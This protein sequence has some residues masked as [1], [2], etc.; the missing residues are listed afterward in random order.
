MAF[1]YVHGALLRA[2]AAQSPEKAQA[3]VRALAQSNQE[4]VAAADPQSP[5]TF[6][7]ALYRGSQLLVVSA[8]H[9]AAESLADRITKHQ[10]RE[11]YL[12]LQQTP[13][14]TGKLLVIDV[15]ADG[16]GPSKSPR[17][18]RRTGGTRGF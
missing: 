15:G 6:V 16:I 8:R 9:P 7:A 13:I 4:A 5:G 17:S 3:L 12:V 10:Y 1:A 18:P 14:A 2:Q 11:A